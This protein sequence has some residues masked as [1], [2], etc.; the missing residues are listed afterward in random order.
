MPQM[1]P[2]FAKAQDE[3]AAAGDAL[4]DARKV[5]QQVKIQPDSKLAMKNLREKVRLAEQRIVAAKSA[6]RGIKSSGAAHRGTK[7]T[8]MH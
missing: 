3:T 8:G 5:L 7:P 1:M 4:K 2:S 6:L